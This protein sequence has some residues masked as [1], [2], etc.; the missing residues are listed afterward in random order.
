MARNGRDI[1]QCINVDPN[2][3]ESVDGGIYKASTKARMMHALLA[4]FEK[5]YEI[6]LH[7][8]CPHNGPV[9]VRRPP[10]CSIKA[11]SP[12]WVAKFQMDGIFSLSRGT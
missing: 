5:E 8:L 11:K 10:G 6:A 3:H 4:G 2:F 9:G 1:I 7:T 12:F